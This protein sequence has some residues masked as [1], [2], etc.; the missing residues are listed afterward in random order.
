MSR[1]TKA[2]KV[3]MTATAR[4]RKA[5]PQA[6]APP[7]IQ[8]DPEFQ[9][10]IPPLSPKERADLQEN[11]QRDGCRDPLVV[12]NGVLL[13]GHH[14]FAICERLKIK[15]TTTALKFQTREAAADW[16]D[17]NQL[18]RRNLAPD[19][20]SL[21]R[22][23]IHHRM[24]RQGA[25]TDRTSAQSEQ[26]S[27]A[28]TALAREHGVSRATIVRDGQFARAVE[29]LK[30]S[31]PDI[32]QRVMNGT[33]PSKAAVIAAARQPHHAREILTTRPARTTQKQK[34]KPQRAPRPPGT[35]LDEPWDPRRNLSALDDAIRSSAVC[36]PADL[37][38]AP[39]IELLQAALVFV[40]GER[41]SRRRAPAA[42]AR[43]PD[44]KSPAAQA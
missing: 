32:E 29:S 12:W 16:I 44:P 43:Q 39:L 31:V 7:P 24:K 33:V 8:I 4:A 25:R 19:Q 35:Q 27:D 41:Q 18:G 20:M 28:A 5:P 3:A 36:W 37:D 13:D 2:R 17:R 30:P 14:R 40:E 42:A 1:P 22:G 21:L 6:P 15:Y 10:L 26:K 38:L 11:L 23:R 34:A 9:K